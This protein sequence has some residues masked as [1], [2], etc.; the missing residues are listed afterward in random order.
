MLKKYHRRSSI[1]DNIAGL[2]ITPMVPTAQNVLDG[3]DVTV[4]LTE[5]KEGEE[6]DMDKDF[7]TI[8]GAINEKQE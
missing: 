3:V 5:Y 4:V 2:E 8:Q 7:E 6:N 1:D